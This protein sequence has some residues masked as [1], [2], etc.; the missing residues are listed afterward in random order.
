MQVMETYGVKGITTENPGVWTT[1]GERKVCAVGVHLR[2][3]VTSHGIGLNVTEEPLSWLGRIVG[4]GL[5]GKGPGSLVTEGAKK[6]GL[7]VEGVAEE[8]VRVF[9]ERLGVD[10]V[11]TMSEDELDVD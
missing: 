4:C 2:R 5:E 8:F 10:G 3:N 6:E 9:G 1:D 7:G 11:V